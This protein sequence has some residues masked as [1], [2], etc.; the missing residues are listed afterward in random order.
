MLR[1]AGVLYHIIYHD[2]DDDFKIIIEGCKVERIHNELLSVL[3]K[4]PRYQKFSLTTTDTNLN[5]KDPSLP[6]IG[7][8]I[9]LHEP[10]RCA[11]SRPRGP[12][13]SVIELTLKGFDNRRQQRE[14][15]DYYGATTAHSFMTDE[16][17]SKLSNSSR[18]FK[19]VWQEVQENNWSANHFM[20]VPH[21]SPID[22]VNRPFP[23]Y[24]HWYRAN[25]DE[26]YRFMI[27]MV[28]FKLDERQLDRAGW[29]S[30]D[31]S[32][33][34]G[35]TDD[36][37]SGNLEHDDISEIKELK[38]ERDLLK[39]V[40]KRIICAGKLGKIV[41][42]PSIEQGEGVLGSCISFVLDNH[43]R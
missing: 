32:P 27:D 30:R 38:S 29:L 25:H 16:Q 39:L 15:Y 20:H 8:W 41:K 37:L 17:C 12:P 5:C 2:P 26:D 21:N 28:L 42:S 34:F 43:E 31:I 14:F 9:K 7:L 10:L 13:I 6:A 4:T 23:L 36:C 11:L 33:Q 19:S 40:G 18:E 3:R 22:I 24:R 35:R 1:G